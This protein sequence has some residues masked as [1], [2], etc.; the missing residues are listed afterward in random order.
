VAATKQIIGMSEF[1]DWVAWFQIK[2][3]AEKDAF[4]KANG[5]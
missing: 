3:E 1:I 2:H 4:D 5:K